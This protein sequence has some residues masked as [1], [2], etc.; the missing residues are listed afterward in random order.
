MPKEHINP[1]EV[2]KHPYYDAIVTVTEPQKIHF[3]AGRCS[4]NDDYSCFAPG[5][6]LAQY[7]RVME[8]LDT[9][10]KVVGA[11]WSDIVQRRVFTLDVDEF[12]RHSAD[13]VIAAYWDPERRPVSTLIGV[14]RLSNP[15]FL[16]EID[17]IAVTG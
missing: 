14:T 5:D 16:V 13:P 10:L 2:F 4:T 17:M 12:L 1:A 6:Y 8:L 11:T 3:F 9:E 7:R 15:E